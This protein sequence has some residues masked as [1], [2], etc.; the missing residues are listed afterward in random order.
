M[1][2]HVVEMKKG[3]KVRDHILHVMNLLNEAEVQGAKNDEDTQIDRLLETLP[4]AFKQFKVNY[5]MNKMKLTMTELMNEV[6]S[7]EDVLI[8]TG[9]LNMVE[10]KT[11]P[12]NNGLNANKKK[13]K[14][15]PKRPSTK[16][17]DKPK[18]KCFKCGEKGHWKKDSPKLNKQG[19]G[20]SFMIEACLV[21]NSIDTWLVDSGATNHICNSLSWF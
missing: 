17:D 16:K 13:K 1:F 4:K 20:N 15:E 19:M 5:K 6:H 10:V 7:V 3:T 12:R 18:R 21:Q 9:S 14:V 8:K 11:K 2:H